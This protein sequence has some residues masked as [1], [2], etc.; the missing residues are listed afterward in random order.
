MK[1]PD[2]WN[3]LS[4]HERRKKIKQLKKDQAHKAIKKQKAIKYTVIVCILIAAVLSF[5]FFIK[6]SP[7]ELEAERA[8]KQEVDAISLEGRVEEFSIE[9]REHVLPGDE[10]SYDTNPPTSGDHLADA[11]SWGVHRDEINDLAG[12]HSL[13]HGGIWISYKDISEEDIAILKEI[14]KQNPQ[15]TVVSPRPS[16]D[17][18]IVVA[19]WGKMMRLDSVDKALIQKYIDTYK[20]QSPEKLAG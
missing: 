3:N 16:N 12:V 10:V 13:E 2:E 8:F 15:S 11:E 1:Y 4:K 19:S 18:N 6:K 7:E 20:N 14:G 5:N 17:N 9:G